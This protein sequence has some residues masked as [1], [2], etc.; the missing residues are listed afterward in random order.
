MPLQAG[1]SSPSPLVERAGVGLIPA[2]P[3]N[4]LYILFLFPF[5][6]FFL[7]NSM[8]FR[9]LYLVTWESTNIQ[10]LTGLGFI[11]VSLISTNIHHYVIE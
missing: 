8:P 11:F 1:S 4:Q 7:I 9:K 5:K 2:F 6:T 3:Q 10:S